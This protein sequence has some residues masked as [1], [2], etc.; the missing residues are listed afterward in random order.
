MK[1]WEFMA[2]FATFA[3]FCSN[4]EFPIFEQKAAKFA[5]GTAKNAKGLDRC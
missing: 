5:K 2:V 4:L 3:S 1:E